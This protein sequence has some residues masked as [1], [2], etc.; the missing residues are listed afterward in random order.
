M[1]IQA[2][3]FFSSFRVREL[4]AIPALLCVAG[5][6]LSQT[7]V[8]EVLPLRYRTAPEV[9][10]IIQPMLARDGSVSGLQGQLI[11]RVGQSVPV[12]ERQV[13]RVVINGQ[14]VEQ[15]VDATQYR[16]VTTG[17]YVL[18]RLSGDRV[19]L[20]VSPQRETLSEAGSRRRERPERGDG[21]FRPARRMDGDRR[22]R[23]GRQRTA[24]GHIRPH[25]NHHA[26]HPA[27]AGQ[28]RGSALSV[29]VA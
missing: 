12:H 10:P 16:D 8:L 9:I 26:R 28:G 15:V 5:A 4:F 23:P 19:T 18:P 22:H 13:R 7:T 20:D 3:V 25:H 2:S 11:V 21:G 1:L 27:R 14:V 24:G 6:A 17:F 29:F